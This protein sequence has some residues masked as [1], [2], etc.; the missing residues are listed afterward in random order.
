MA[1]NA[2][3]KADKAQALN[4]KIINENKLRSLLDEQNS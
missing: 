2:G 4:I 1:E 3:S